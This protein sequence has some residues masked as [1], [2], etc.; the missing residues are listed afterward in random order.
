MWQK[1]WMELDSYDTLKEARIGVTNLIHSGRIYAQPRPHCVQIGG[2]FFLWA[3]TDVYVD[4]RTRWQ[5]KRNEMV[6]SR[7]CTPPRPRARLEQRL[8]PRPRRERCHDRIKVWTP[9]P[10]RPKGQPKRCRRATTLMR[11]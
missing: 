1:K 9:R 10:I 5:S 11:G 8:H 7:K 2:G 6:F 4:A 3:V